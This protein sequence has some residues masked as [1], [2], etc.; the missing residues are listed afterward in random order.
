V[1][2]RKV[3]DVEVELVSESISSG[4]GHV[5]I[6]ARDTSPVCAKTVEVL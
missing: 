3:I 1:A 5:R 4:A 6:E 2:N